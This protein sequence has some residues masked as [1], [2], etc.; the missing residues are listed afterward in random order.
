MV[1]D[2]QRAQ[3]RKLGAGQTEG[4]LN[5][6][7][8][9]IEEQAAN[10]GDLAS[11]IVDQGCAVAPADAEGTAAGQARPHG[12]ACAVHVLPRD[13]PHARRRDDHVIDGRKARVGDPAV[14]HEAGELE[15]G[16][17]AAVGPA[18]VC[19]GASAACPEG[20]AR[21]GAARGCR[22]R[23]WFDADVRRSEGGHA[24]VNDPRPSI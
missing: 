23:R 8:E 24:P 18:T 22:L 14:E 9:R 20:T 6:E 17:Q 11:E 10:R 16:G 12:D 1:V 2:A 21:D 4:S 19:G 15:L 7:V 3:Q 5:G 13:D